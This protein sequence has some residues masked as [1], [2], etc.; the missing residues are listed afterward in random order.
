[1]LASTSHGT[2]EKVETNALFIADWTEVICQVIRNYTEIIF[3]M[4]ILLFPSAE[5]IQ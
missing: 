1:M 5:E 3:R 4:K 2:P